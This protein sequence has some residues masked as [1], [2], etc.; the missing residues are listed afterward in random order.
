MRPRGHQPGPPAPALED[1]LALAAAAHRG[2]VY[3]SPTGE[4]YILHP[5]RVMLRVTSAA[6]RV[7]ALLHD[8]VEDTP[9][10]LADLRRFGYSE[11][12][13]AAIDR[14]TRRDGEPY[15]AYIER[16]AGD[17][18]A[19]RV[20]LADLA[21]NLANNRRLAPTAPVRE[22]LARYQRAR[23]RLLRADTRTPDGP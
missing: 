10:T 14:L 7:V 13:V 22:R 20:K 16:L 4:P 23:A 19:R 9:T 17:P 1:A 6:E 15:E 2:Q 3:P 11:A 21:D 18:L 5:L 12:V 8:V